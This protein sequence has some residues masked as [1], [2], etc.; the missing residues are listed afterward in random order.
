MT[1]AFFNDT[2]MGVIPTLPEVV[3]SMALWLACFVG[4]FLLTENANTAI[5]LKLTFLDMRPF[6]CR[7][8]LSTHLTWLSFLFAAYAGGW[9]FLYLGAMGSCWIYY[10][11]SHRDDE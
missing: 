11:L 4:G 9:H 1:D 8:C 2:L 5:W 10:I 7:L 3:I 6:N